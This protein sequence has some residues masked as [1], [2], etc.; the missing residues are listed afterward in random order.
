MLARPGPRA[1]ESRNIP[2]NSRVL[3]WQQGLKSR[4]SDRDCADARIQI[5]ASS[6]SVQL[7]SELWETFVAESVMVT[8]APTMTAP[9]GSVTVPGMGL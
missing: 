9:E 3:R 8:C 2:T 5:V 7:V 1:P 4:G 6:D